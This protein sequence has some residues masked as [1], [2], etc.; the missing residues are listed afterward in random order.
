MVHK[1]R[2]HRDWG[3]LNLFTATLNQE[4]ELLET[5]VAQEDREDI[6]NCQQGDEDA[7]ARLIKRYEILISRQMWRFTRDPQRLEELVQEVFV[8]A[9]TSLGSFKGTAPFEHWLRKIAT[10]VGYRFWKHK[11]S[12][13]ERREKLEQHK[14]EITPSTGRTSPSEAAEYLF[15]LLGTLP[16]QERMVLTLLYFEGWGTE[17]I[18]QHLG[19]TRSLVKVRAFRARKKLKTK[20]EIAGYAKS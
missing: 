8:E 19:W 17:E 6:R 5:S 18:A 16:A 13:N 11:S 1:R 14:L 2:T 4:F 20:L 12:D 9:Y 3:G 7:Y 10:R 15:N